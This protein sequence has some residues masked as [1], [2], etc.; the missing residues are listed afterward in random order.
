M[1]GL[2]CTLEDCCHFLEGITF[3]VITDHKNMEW[4]SAMQ[5]LNRQQACWSLYLSQFNF[6]V[7]YRK[8]E[9]MQAG[10]L[11]RFAQD[12]VHNREDNQQL[13]ILGP[14]HF[15]TVAAAHY[16]PA[17]TDYLGDCI[18]LASQQE[19]EVIEGL[20][21]IDKTASKAL[22]DSTALW[23]E[24]DSYMYYK[25]KL[26]VPNIRELHCDIVKTCHNSLIMRHPGKN[27]TIE[28]VS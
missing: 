23:E 1:L 19:A 24:E 26:H 13:C 9:S 15:E 16:K 20:K 11:S 12:H 21:S 6:K 3:K 17:S 7:T 18:C 28:L 27:D 25:G 22:T 10:A 14:Q 2:I 8:G 5:D 4:W